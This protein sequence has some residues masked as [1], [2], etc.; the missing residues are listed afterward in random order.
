ML[1]VIIILFI[2]APLAELYVLLKVGSAIGPLTT[3]LLAI[4]TA[5]IGTLLV[6]QQGF[7]VLR[8][9]QQQMAREELPALD[10][11]DGALLLFA[12]LLLLFPGFITDAIGFALL[13]PPLRRLVINRY[14]QI[15]P[16]RSV[17]PRDPRS[18]DRDEGPRVID[19]DYR[20]EK[21]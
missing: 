1:P 18:M 21:D 7:T 15:I 14:V 20:R 19:G 10:M 6:R 12:G 11:F 16:I 5:V 2:A 17:D 9:V 4:L 3:I 8:R 13:V